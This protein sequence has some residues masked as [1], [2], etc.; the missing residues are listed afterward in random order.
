MTVP[1]EIVLTNA[2][3]VLENEV[4][5]GTI[6]L[7]NGIIHD[8]TKGNSQQ[9]EDIDGE[10]I[11]PG[12]VELHTDHVEAHYT[13]RPKVTW[14][15]YAAI[16]A[17]DVQIAG[18]GITTVL[19]ALRVGADEGASV[20]GEQMR[21]L[22]DAIRLSGERDVLRADHFLHIRCEVSAPDCLNSFERF[23]E[24][25]RVRL[26]SLMDH[27]PGQRQFSNLDAYRI[28]YMGK[29]GM[30]DDE[31][32]RFCTR[33]LEESNQYSQGN[34]QEVAR[35]CKE[36]D[37]VLASHDDATFDHVDEALRD[38]ISVAEFPTTTEAAKASHE[39]GLDV[40]MGAPNLIRGGSHSGNV[41]AGDLANS[42]HLDILSS[43]YIPFSLI[44][45]A[46]KLG[47]I[48]NTISLPEAV[49][50]VTANPARAVGLDDRGVLDVGKR[51]DIVHVNLDFEVPTI[52]SVWR[53]AKRVV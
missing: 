13:P 5:N 11:I 30:T 21:V 41:S 10:T 28:Y 25:D 20:S 3:L 17:H 33:R 34:R 31:F 23:V 9:G 2:R 16:A 14:N 45:A 51:A 6:V 47:D 37:L 36:R 40:L 46:F 19:D 27:A 24:D 8:I 38:G 26:V 49:K 50:K 1:E 52:R 44:T 43:D 42:G 29:H 12:L 53:Q 48:A 35:L 22:A 15:P 7:K 4:I 32:S 18:S 39:N